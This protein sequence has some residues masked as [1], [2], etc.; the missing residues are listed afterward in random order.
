MAS[1]ISTVGLTQKAGRSFRQRSMPWVDRRLRRTGAHQSSGG[2]TCWSS[3]RASSWTAATC[4]RSVASGRTWRSRFQWRPWPTSP[5]HRRLTL[6]GRSRFR[7][8]LLGGWLAM[9][10]SRRCSSARSRTSRGLGRP[11]ARSAV[12]SAGLWWSGIRAAG[13]PGVTGHLIGLMR[14][15]SNIGPTAAS[16]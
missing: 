3:W 6:R 12:R 16:T 8:R 14:T 1:S 9:L 15:I 2:L 11:A 4:R 7:P 10:R 13:S 5:A